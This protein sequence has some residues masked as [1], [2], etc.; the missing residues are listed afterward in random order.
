MY[1]YIGNLPMET[2]EADLAHLFVPYG[3]TLSVC[4]PRDK[5]NGHPLGM[6]Y[7]EVTSEEQGERAI[8]ELNR[9]RIGD[10]TVL[11]SRAHDRTE[12]R[13]N[14]GSAQCQL[15]KCHVIM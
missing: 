3:G 4:M 7:I 13:K 15:T 5:V 1:V 2:S 9:T 8:K 10:R 12:R 11:V 6:A 14:V